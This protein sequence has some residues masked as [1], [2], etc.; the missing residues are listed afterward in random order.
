[1]S[2][3]SFWR[4]GARHWS[5]SFQA[6]WHS[7]RDR[8]VG[9]GG[10]GKRWEKLV[11]LLPAPKEWGAKK[12]TGKGRI[13]VGAWVFSGTFCL[14]GKAGFVR[15]LSYFLESSYSGTVHETKVLRTK[16]DKKALKYCRNFE[17]L[18]NIFRG[19]NLWRI[20]RVKKHFNTK[21]RATST[22]LPFLTQWRTIKFSTFSSFLLHFYLLL[23]LVSDFVFFSLLSLSPSVLQKSKEKRPDS[24]CLRFTMYLTET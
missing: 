1:M 11:V 23:L 2:N 5:Y 21:D 24:A 6:G 18:P 8:A 12:N 20:P 16:E 14:Q 15:E 3:I 4:L 13:S 7:G 10:G 9:G 19:P 22:V 17:G